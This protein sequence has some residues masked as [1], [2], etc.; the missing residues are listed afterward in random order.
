[1]AGS[2]RLVTGPHL[3]DGQTATIR[4][5]L[6][7]DRG[8]IARRIIR[9]CRMLGIETVGIHGEADG[10]LP[11][12]AEADLAVRLAPATEPSRRA[13]LAAAS[14]DQLLDA[15]RRTGADAVHPG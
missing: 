7:V 9:T 12:L 3:S 10:A 1:M 5:L 8:A 6:L 11:H 15:A 4:R 2:P 13:P 14:I